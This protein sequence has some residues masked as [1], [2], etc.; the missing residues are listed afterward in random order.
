MGASNRLSIEEF[1]N[2][3]SPRYY[4]F[5]VNELR[6]T[7]KNGDLLAA[8]NEMKSWGFFAPETTWEKINLTE[9]GKIY[10]KMIKK[11]LGL[12]ALHVPQSNGL[13]DYRTEPG[14][15]VIFELMRF[16]MARFNLQEYFQYLNLPVLDPDVPDQDVKTLMQSE[17]G[18]DFDYR[19]EEGRN[20]L[21]NFLKKRSTRK[22]RR[23]TDTINKKF[24]QSAAAVTFDL[25]MVRRFLQEKGL[26]RPEPIFAH[27]NSVEPKIFEVHERQLSIY[28]PELR[29]IAETLEEY[30]ETFSAEDHSWLADYFSLVNLPTEFFGFSLPGEFSFASEKA[31]TFL[32]LAWEGPK[33]FADQLSNYK[34]LGNLEL[35]LFPISEQR[36][37]VISCT[38]LILFY[39]ALP[40]DQ[41]AYSIKSSLVTPTHHFLIS[42][43]RSQ[44][45]DVLQYSALPKLISR[46]EPSDISVNQAEIVKERGFLRRG[47]SPPDGK[48]KD[49]ELEK[50]EMVEVQ[51]WGYSIASFFSICQVIAE[52]LTPEFLIPQ[53]TCIFEHGVL[54]VTSFVESSNLLATMNLGS[55]EV[56]PEI[57]KTL[58]K[59]RTSFGHI[60]DLKGEDQDVKNHDVKV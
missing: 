18:A 34:D 23:T 45:G 2:F 28:M 58:G 38:G 57:S 60:F 14:R 24:L 7:V 53:A 20:S 21:L 37:I 50:Q 56:G 22:V 15:R 25:R 12:E 46:K 27:F 8:L 4:R 17:L 48:E 33:F 43:K 54:Y 1:V 42:Q 51:R 39:L 47:K 19:T 6:P 52:K 59:I 44:F 36:S 41:C 55:I 16:L 13:F 5:V 9:K 40:G 30:V 3:T 32:N 29:K 26:K 31:D 35:I 10:T 49:K 11:L